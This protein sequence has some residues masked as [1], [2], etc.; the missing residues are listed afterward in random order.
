M[1]D[2]IA[3]ANEVDIFRVDQVSYFVET[4]RVSAADADRP[5]ISFCSIKSGSCCVAIISEQDWEG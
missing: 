1:H 3:D 2:D 4:V 5:R